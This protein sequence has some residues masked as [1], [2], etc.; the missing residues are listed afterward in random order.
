MMGSFGSHLYDV[1]IC[2]DTQ[3]VSLTQLVQ[4]SRDDAHRSDTD[5]QAFYRG[6]RAKMVAEGCDYLRLVENDGVSH[7]GVVLNFDAITSFKLATSKS[8][9]PAP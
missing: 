7:M 6:V 3:D 8:S 4:W 1:E 5:S 2:A 9:V